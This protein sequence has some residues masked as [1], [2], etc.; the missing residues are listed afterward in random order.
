MSSGWYFGIRKFKDDQEQKM[1]LITEEYPDVEYPKGKINKNMFVNVGFVGF[2]QEISRDDMIMVF[3]D[4]LAFL[5]SKNRW[6]RA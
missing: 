1:F 4:I 2:D 5:E 6:K 3:K